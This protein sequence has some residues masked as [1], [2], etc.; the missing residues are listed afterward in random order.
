MAQKKAKCMPANLF[1]QGAYSEL[2]VLK[3][4]R[5]D[6]PTMSLA[7]RIL[8]FCVVQDRE[9]RPLLCECNPA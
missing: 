3:E 8:K 2:S 9:L 4:A 6:R 5:G 7:L 1:L